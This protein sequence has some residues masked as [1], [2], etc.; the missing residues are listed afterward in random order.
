MKS[1]FQIS[2]ANEPKSS[3]TS[4]S[5]IAT[6]VALGNQK[7]APKTV[8]SILSNIK[9]DTQSNISPPGQVKK[10]NIPRPVTSANSFSSGSQNG[11]MTSVSRTASNASASRLSGMSKNNKAFAPKK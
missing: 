3:T 10:S 11:P 1:F 6:A 9:A 2:K 8:A 4:G 5:T 7:S